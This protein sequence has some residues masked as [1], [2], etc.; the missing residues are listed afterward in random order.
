MKILIYIFFLILTFNCNALG[1]NNYIFNGGSSHGFGFDRIQ[2]ISNNGIFSGG[3]DH[4]FDQLNLSESSKKYAGGE[5]D[6]FGFMHKDTDAGNSIFHG[7]IEDGMAFQVFV[8]TSN[9]GVFEGGIHDG[10]DY[11]CTSSAS[12]SDLFAGGEGDGFSASGISKLIWDGDISKDWLMADN[13][14]IPI[15]PTMNHMACIPSGA[16]RYPKLTSILGISIN[17]EH[18]YASSNVMIMNGAVI[19]GIENVKVVV[20]GK[21]TVAGN[22]F[23]NFDGENVKI[24]NRQEGLIKILTGGRIIID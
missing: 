20:N 14:N 16:P 19:N 12:N 15:V 3:F 4:G 11:S 22:L 5:E 17:E 9:S 8:Q 7:S 6:G 18:T 21:L 23:L 24:E 10:F 2:S 13:W 1:Q